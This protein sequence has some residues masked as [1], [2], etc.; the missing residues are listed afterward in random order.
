MKN[1]DVY[2]QGKRIVLDDKQGIY[3]GESFVYLHNGMAIKVY[4]S[5]FI[6]KWKVEKIKNFPKN[7][8]GKVISPKEI[9]TDKNG[10]IIGYAMQ[11]LTDAEPFLML[12]LP[13]FRA[14]FPPEK[15][16]EIFLDCLKTLMGIHA[17]KTVVS[18]LNNLNILFKNTEAYFIDADSMQFGRFA[19][20]VAT[21]KY[22]D[23]FLYGKDFNSLVFT[24]ES[25]YYSF[26][27]MLFESLLFANPYGGVHLKYP[28]LTKRA[29][30]RM[31]VFNP[32]VKYPKAAIPFKVLSDDMLEYF[33]K[34]FEKDL[35]GIFP[36]NLL[37]NLRWTKCTACGE[38]HARNLC[39]YCAHAAPSAIKTLALVNRKCI[40]KIIFQ[41]V[42]RIIAAKL[43][44]GKPKFVYEENGEVKRESGE[45]V[46]AGNPDNFTRFSIMNGKTLIGRKNKLAIVEKSQ[47]TEEM[48]VNMLG[49]LPV[50]ESSD[51]DYVRTSG[52]MLVQNNNQILGQILENQTWIKLGK[53]FG[54]GFYRIG[55]KTVYFIFQLDRPGINDSVALPKIE[56]QLI[57]ANCIF[58]EKNILFLISTKEAGKLWNAMYLLDIQ[59]NLAASAKEE[60]SSSRMLSGIHNKVLGGDKILTA[61]DEGI[62]LLEADDQKKIREVKIF[63][64]T[65]PFVNES[66]EILSGPEGIYVIG[67]NDI[68]L[69]KLI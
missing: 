63:S 46:F 25:D 3:G 43:E 29:E 44:G 62:M 13:K 20:G 35:R 22:L 8:P 15:V 47:V 18:D 24:P 53:K 69:L 52:G 11:A 36:A 59:G 26:A 56:G 50:F 67:K 49:N 39:P 57:D 37:E 32:E 65:E 61:T 41:T 6:D 30:K 14:N 4:H 2:L 1:M 19:C 55:M 9:V 17:A 42:G 68:K 48:Q 60:Q 16:K 40:A 33:H 64:D 5:G 58:S 54:F 12:S 31:T 27:V 21:E 23:P 66:V 38:T 10:K 28:T 7:L 51:A 34:V 45:Q